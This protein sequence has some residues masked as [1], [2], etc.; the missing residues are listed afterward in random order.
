MGAGHRRYSKGRKRFH[1]RVRR[2]E[3]GIVIILITLTLGDSFYQ[4][5][6][7][8]GLWF[9]VIQLPGQGLQLEEEKNDLEC[10]AMKQ[11]SQGQKISLQSLQF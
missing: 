5:K 6:Q 3:A 11:N 1:K 8:R 9:E 4:V 10:P 2:E 7:K